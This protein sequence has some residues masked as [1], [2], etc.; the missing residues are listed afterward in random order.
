MVDIVNRPAGMVFPSSDAFYYD[1]ESIR[2]LLGKGFSADSTHVM[3]SAFLA[4]LHKIFGLDYLPVV[5]AQMAVYA[6]IPVFLY[7][8]TSNLFS[9]FSGLLAASLFILRERN[10]LLLGGNVTGIGFNIMMSENLALLTWVA[11]FYLVILW[12]KNP[13]SRSLLPW[14]A[15]GL[16]GISILTR[17]EMLAVYLAVGLGT[18]LVLWN[19]KSL[20]LRGAVTFTLAVI[21]V[22]GPWMI[23]NWQQAGR[24][25]IDKVDFVQ[26]VV[27]QYFENDSDPADHIS[28]N[29][30][31]I[32]SYSVYAERRLHGTSIKYIPARFSNSLLQTVLYLPTNHQPFLT[33]GSILERGK[34]GSIRFSRQGVFSEKYLLR[35]TR[36]LPYFWYIWDGS[37]SIRSYLPLLMVLFLCSLG[38]WVV[39]NK[40][41]IIITIPVLAFSA[42]LLIWALAGYSGGRFIKLV[43]WI[44]LLFYSIGLT[45][46]IS[47]FWRVIVNGRSVTEL[48]PQPEIGLFSLQRVI[49]QRNRWLERG[50]LAFV[51]L[52][53]TA[54]TI[55]E[56]L[57][58]QQYTEEKKAQVVESI[59]VDIKLD[60]GQY[61]YLY[62]KMLYPRF[63]EANEKP[64][65]DRKGTIPNPTRDRMDF[66]LIGTR[67]I[68]VSYPTNQPV[69]S[70][71]HDVDVIVEGRIVRDTSFD[72]MYGGKQPYFLASRVLI[73]K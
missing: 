35:Y 38:I 2:F 21:L 27:S 30:R 58:P 41:N 57:I 51:L 3:Y 15:G 32:P 14:I 31:D 22:V 50:A 39:G 40:H 71:R 68:W 65:D 48:N 33:A 63:Y 5:T 1:K 9:T 70:F 10:M 54:P 26:R 53:G 24:L 20:W 12:V 64:L 62:G 36:N 66:Y 49:F 55:L 23:R 43:D 44:P 13:Q 61:V 46:L 59:H 69:E 47:I 72:L 16:M 60:K 8:I 25:S 37:L 28:T 56:P 19:K 11:L 45:V 29:R 7:L 52:I 34:E 17:V 73:I 67:T 6:L 42:H 4:A 18:L